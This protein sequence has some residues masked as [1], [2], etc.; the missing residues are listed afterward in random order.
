MYGKAPLFSNS[1]QYD[2]QN[3]PI[4]SGNKG[5]FNYLHG[6]AHFMHI[7]SRPGF[8]YEIT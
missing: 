6:N 8:F 1:Y 5:I 7:F 3:Q 2:F 4:S